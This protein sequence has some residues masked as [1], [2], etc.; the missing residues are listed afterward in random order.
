MKKVYSIVLL[1]LEKILMLR[2]WRNIVFV[3]YNIPQGV[4]D[5]VELEFILDEGLSYIANSMI[6]IPITA[7]EDVTFGGVWGI[8]NQSRIWY[9]LIPVMMEQALADLGRLYYRS[10]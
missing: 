5:D 8:M 2:R 4:S 1:Y 6:L 3:Y 9:L 7:S 10:W